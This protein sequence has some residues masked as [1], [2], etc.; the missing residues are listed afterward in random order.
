MI[1]KCYKIGTIDHKFIIFLIKH[2][3]LNNYFSQEMD[4]T[5]GPKGNATHKVNWFE[6]KEG[7]YYWSKLC[8]SWMEE[9]RKLNE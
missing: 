7:W 8:T 1:K 9:L 2:K 5:V 4:C 3:A 6:S